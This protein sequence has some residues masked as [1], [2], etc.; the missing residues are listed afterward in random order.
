M[1]LRTRYAALVVVA[2]LVL[3]VIVLPRR[4][5]DRPPDRA[6]LET[7]AAPA[8]PSPTLMPDLRTPL[9]T[10]APAE[11]TRIAQTAGESAASAQIGEATAAAVAAGGLLFVPAAPTTTAEVTIQAQLASGTS[12]AGQVRTDPMSGISVVGLLPADRA[13][14]EQIVLGLSSTLAIGDELAI[15]VGPSAP[16]VKVLYLGRNQVMNERFGVLQDVLDM[17]LPDGVGL[18]QGLVL[19]GQGRVVGVVT[20]DRQVAAPPG[21]VFGIPVE[22]AA[23]MFRQ[24]GAEL[25]TPE[26]TVTASPRPTRPADD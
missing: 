18:E 16:P 22:M 23:D 8:T 25:P 4:V 21:R 14:G 2:V 17:R 9:A 3:L 26:P 19:D 6:V 15:A 1:T 7:I 20:P 11:A 5:V 12:V 10:M 13:S 24:V